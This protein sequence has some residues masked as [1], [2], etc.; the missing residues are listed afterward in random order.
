M[1]KITSKITVRPARVEDASFITDCQIKMAFETEEMKLDPPTVAKGVGAV[2]SD[3]TKGT[4][5]VACN[6]TGPIACVLT[7]P[8][9]SDWRN[10]TVLWIHSL[11]VI[12]SQRGHGVYRQMHEFL[13][14][15]VQQSPNLRG[16]RLY[17]D[18]RNTHAQA[19]YQKLEMTNEHYAMFEWMKS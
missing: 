6:D 1:E 17:V 14:A 8:E 11:Y 3:P 16:L 13:K 12:P 7:I 15:K 18:K 19:V 10:G 5:F 9:W 4:Y 2:F